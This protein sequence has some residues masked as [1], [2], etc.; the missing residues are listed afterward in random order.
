[1]CHDEYR[2]VTVEAAKM[3]KVAV[4]IKVR[5]S[6]K[7]SD[8]HRVAVNNFIVLNYKVEIVKKGTTGILAIW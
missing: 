2:L 7:S 4:V 1:M 8:I 6:S 5:F 3:L